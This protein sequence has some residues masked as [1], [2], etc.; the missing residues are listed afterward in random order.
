MQFIK[1]CSV[2]CTN[3]NTDREASEGKLRTPSATEERISVPS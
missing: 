2:G 1:L 3:F